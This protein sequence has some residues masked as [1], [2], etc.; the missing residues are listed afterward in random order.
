MEMLN[1]K[2]VLQSR[3]EGDDI[4]SD[5]ILLLE[6]RNTKQYLKDCLGLE[7]WL[8]HGVFFTGDYNNFT[9]TDKTV[10]KYLQYWLDLVHIIDSM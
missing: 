8:E 5:E 1:I 4:Y 9:S 10:T 3:F 6:I 7:I 2:N